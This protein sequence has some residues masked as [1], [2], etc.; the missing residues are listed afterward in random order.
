MQQEKTNFRG[1]RVSG[2]REERSA[3]A[4]TLSRGGGFGGGKVTERQARK[5][6][7]EKAS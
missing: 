2:N 6:L 3:T 7:L 4:E 1:M 5:V